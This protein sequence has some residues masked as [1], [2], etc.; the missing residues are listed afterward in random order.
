[1]RYLLI[2]CAA[3]ALLFSTACNSPIWASGTPEQGALRQEIEEQFQAGN[4]TQEVRDGMLA[5]L[6]SVASFSDA[7]PSEFDWQGMLTALLGIGGVVLGGAGARKASVA[8]KE[9]K[10]RGPPKPLDPD[11]FQ[12]LRKVLDERLKA[13]PQRGGKQG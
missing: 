4:I 13:L 8:R 6:D 9:L 2:L 12:A 11:E 10:E 5:A 7:R 1:M 3:L